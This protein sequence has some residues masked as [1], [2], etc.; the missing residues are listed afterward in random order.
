MDGR[1]QTQ[2]LRP[3]LQA[4]SIAFSNL[5]V[6]HL[7]ENNHCISALVTC[8]KLKICVHKVRTVGECTFELDLL[9][10]QP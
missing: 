7:S 10:S 5:Y 4:L 9:E 6:I 8:D 3:K 2:V 1:E